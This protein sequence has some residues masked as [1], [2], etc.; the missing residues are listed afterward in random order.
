MTRTQASTSAYEWPSIGFVVEKLLRTIN[1]DDA[2]AL[3]LRILELM[4]AN[5]AGND[6]W[7]LT[8][9]FE[10]VAHKIPNERAAQIAD[11]ILDR[12]KETA[13]SAQIAGLGVGARGFGSEENA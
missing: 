11:Q 4:N 6:T 2:S 7:E 13:S 3:A 9:P 5:I 1:G 12:M 8:K 10:T